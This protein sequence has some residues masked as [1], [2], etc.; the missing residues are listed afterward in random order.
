[1]QKK[2]Y[3]YKITNPF[4]KIYIGSTINVK[5]RLYRYRTNRL[6]GQYKISN[7]ISKY[8]W[9]SH[10]FEIVYEC[11]LEDRNKY[12]NYYGMIFDS[13]GDNGLNLCLPKY[14]D[15]YKCMSEETKSKIGA[16]HKGKTI[17]IHQ[18]KIISIR[19]KKY[20]L[21][22]GSP[23]KSIIPWNKGAKLLSGS[24]NPMFGVRRSEDWKKKHSILMKEKL[25]KGEFHYKSKVVFNPNNGIF[26]DSVKELSNLIKMKYSTLKGKLNG[27][28]KNDTPYIYV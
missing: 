16:K 23:F 21:E 25:A 10:L 13:I 22:N 4:N 11:N 19:M 17:S 6:K 18:R 20:F 12:E 1:M 9:E 15:E 3:I 2:A 26:Y 5:D 7:S 14:N 27:T 8:G 24:N 28:A